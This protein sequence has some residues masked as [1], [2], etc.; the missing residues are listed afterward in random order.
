MATFQTSKAIQDGYVRQRTW[1]RGPVLCNQEREDEAK[2][3]GPEIA[4]KSRFLTARI[5]GSCR[6]WSIFEGKGIDFGVVPNPLFSMSFRASY[7]L[8]TVVS[9]LVM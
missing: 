8:R 1:Q 7:Y 5:A 9:T 2:I 6:F 3:G 4:E